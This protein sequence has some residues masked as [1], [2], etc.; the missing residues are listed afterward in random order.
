M[1]IRRVTEISVLISETGGSDQVEIPKEA[2][3]STPL[4]VLR[5][6][7]QC[8]CGTLNKGKSNWEVLS[9]SDFG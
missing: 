9:V 6:D 1:N 4:G 2:E 8:A 7:W 5:G 3:K